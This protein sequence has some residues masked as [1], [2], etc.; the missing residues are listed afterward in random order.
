MSIALGGI[1]GGSLG[2][3]AGGF[4]AS[5]LPNRT[6]DDMI[7]E[8]NEQQKMN[9]EM[10]NNLAN[11]LRPKNRNSQPC[12]CGNI[13]Q[14]IRPRNVFILKST[15]KEAYETARHWPGARGVSHHYHNTY[16]GDNKPHYHPTFDEEGKKHIPGIHIRYPK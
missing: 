6:Y 16:P 14:C 5:R 13:N 11:V 3:V 12:C 10:C 7:R 9:D 2:N 4:A 8:F 15:K 1:F